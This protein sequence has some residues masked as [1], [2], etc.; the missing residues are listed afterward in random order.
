METAVIDSSTATAVGQDQAGKGLELLHIEKS[1][2][3]VRAVR[4]VTFAC[5]P[6]EIHALLGGNGAGKSTLMAIATGD[7]APDAGQVFINGQRLTAAHP[8]FARDMGLRMVFQDQSLIPDLDVAQNLLLAAGGGRKITGVQAWAAQL[9]DDFEMPISPRA[10]VRDLPVAA[11]QIVEIVKT[12][13][14]EPK[15]LILDEPTA[16]LARNEVAHLL[17]ILRR[18]ANQGVAVVYI[19]HRLP[20]VFALADRASVMRDGEMVAAGEPVSSLDEETLVRLMAGRTFEALV[21]HDRGTTAQLGQ[22]PLL[23]IENYSGATFDDVAMKV[24]PGEIVGIGGIEGNGQR[25]FLRSIAGIEGAVGR[26]DVAGHSV[27]RK[28]VRAARAAGLSFVSSDRSRESLFRVLSVRENMTIGSI[29]ALARLGIIQ[30]RAEHEAA[31]R[32]G[33][34][35]ALKTPSMEAPV[36]VLSGGNQ[37]KVAVGRAIMSE[38]RIYLVDE[39]TQGVDAGAR[40]QLYDLLRAAAAEGTAVVVLSSDG[41]ELCR[42]CDRVLVFG[43]GRITRE[44]RGAE[45]T[46]ENIVAGSARAEGGRRAEAVGEYAAAVQGPSLFKL[47]RGSDYL[48]VGLVLVAIVCLGLFLGFQSQ[49]FFQRQNMADLLFLAVPLGFAALGQA[50]T[51]LVGKLDLSIGPVIAVTTIA[52]ATTM[53]AGGPGSEWLAVTLS[54][55]IGLAVGVLNA[56]LVDRVQLVPFIATLATYILIQGVALCWLPFP[57]GSISDAFSQAT[58]AS[59]GPVPWAFAALAALAIGI[60]LIFR[61]SRFG[62]LFRA[63]GSKPASARRLGVRSGVIHYGVYLFAGLMAAVG[64][65]F[66]ASTI[67]VG[68]PTLGVSFTLA[69]FS[70][71]VVGGLSTWGGRGSLVGPLLGALFFAMLQNGTALLNLPA[72]VTFFA[73]GGLC[74]LTIG[75]YSRLRSEGANVDEGIGR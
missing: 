12:L 48:P 14:A 2:P 17:S 31:V 53:E 57:G 5:L 41:E 21:H 74:L 67:G 55:A 18:V 43:N 72:H 42:L 9:L 39:P 63:V 50:A 11:R 46:E 7:L 13:M 20:E 54:L 29:S 68:D 52:A 61:R 59:L 56:L 23:E 70:A 40:A 62:L 28:S 45:L 51:M 38:P 34:R 3:G 65:L 1:F 25:E 24:F 73:Q 64:G 33:N 32:V 44:L 37:Q 58:R 22:A 66:F 16:A 47:A 60:E 49:Y 69:S 15:V 75:L 71:V 27:P 30:P 6:G 4:D 35:L 19:T 10:I 36:A 26:L 8:R